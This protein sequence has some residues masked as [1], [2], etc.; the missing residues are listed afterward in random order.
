MSG[1]IMTCTVVLLLFVG[2]GARLLPTWMFFNSLQLIAHTPMLATSMPPN[3]NYFLI[4]YLSIV[5]FK[6]QSFEQKIE[7]WQRD[8]GVFNYSI[9]TSDDSQ[10]TYLLNDCGYKF[11][12]YRN[13]ILFIVLSTCFLV[14]LAILVI[15]DFIKSRSAPSKRYSNYRRAFWMTNFTLRFVY[16]FFFEICLCLLIHVSVA[17]EGDIFMYFMSIVL[18]AA[19]LAFIAV[20]FAF[21]CRWGPYIVP[22]SY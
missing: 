17:H 9:L 12:F 15:L 7:A 16:E 4:R 11:A 22:K 2:T 10:F 5:R 21:F 18:F 8:S 1:S 13:L 20:L 19:M 6:L 14:I 3:L